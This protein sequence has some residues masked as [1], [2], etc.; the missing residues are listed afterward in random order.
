MR[1]TF[2][3]PKTLFSKTVKNA[4]RCFK[5]IELVLSDAPTETFILDSKLKFSLYCI[6][7]H[8]SLVDICICF[9]N[10]QRDLPDVIK[11]DLPNG[12][13]TKIIFV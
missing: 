11:T 10:A 8:K 3:N 1:E 9:C 6:F 7:S 13:F 12:F 2:K 5:A 4:L